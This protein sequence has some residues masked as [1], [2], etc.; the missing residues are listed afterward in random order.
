MYFLRHFAE[1]FDKTNT[2]TLTQL[3]LES[4][5]VLNEHNT[6]FRPKRSA[7]G[8]MCFAG[9]TRLVDANGITIASAFFA[10]LTRWQTDWQT[11]LLGR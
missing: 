7:I 2:G 11:T 9:P 5:I 4:C 3:Q 10:E 1:A 6:V 8:N